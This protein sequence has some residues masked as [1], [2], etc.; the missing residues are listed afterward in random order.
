MSELYERS[1]EKLELDRVLEL[2]A[3]RA[4]CA[5]AKARC[6]SLRPSG[7]LEDVRQALDETTAACTMSQVK[8][9]PSFYDVKDV[10]AAL[11]RAD[12]GGCLSTKELLQIAGVLRCARNAAAYCG[13]E[14][15]DSILKP[16]FSALT[17]NKY[18]EEKITGAILSEEEIADSA[19]PEL[20]DIRR[21]IRIQGAKIKDGLQKIIS[22]PSFAKYLRDP[23]ITIRQDRYVVPVKSEFKNEIPGLVHDVSASGSTFFI[24]PMSAVNA[25]NALR[26]LAIREKKE[27]ERILAELSAEAAA[28]RDTISEDYRLMVELDVIFAKAKLSYAM[29]AGAPEMNDRGEIELRRARHPLIDPKKVVPISLRLGSD[30]DT[31]II[32]GPNTGGKTVTLK[33]IGLL[34]LMAECGL[35]IP[36]GDGSRLSTFDRVL[37][38]IGDE[39]SIAQSLSTF[40]GHMRTIVDVVDQC[41]DRSL[42]LFDELGAGTDPAEGAALAMA[43]I[44]Y[45]RKTGSRVAATTHYAELKLYAMRT[46]GV[47]NASCEFNVETCLK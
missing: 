14:D 29:G 17:P 5:D 46:D 22:S 4:C 37:A 31:L 33:T 44:E 19:S 20:S 36:A 15:A 9:S 11:E 23:I 18:L 24:E 10:N 35:H 16:R 25:N 12:R 13:D 43:L 38:D 45:C 41:D 21:H 27:I 40:S 30:F 34:T 8:G 39:Q 6:R 32:T 2:L 26:E 7:D 3:E 1:M 28:Y 47:M 42:V